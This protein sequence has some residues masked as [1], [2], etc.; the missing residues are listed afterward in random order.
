VGQNGH[1]GS[2]GY[3]HG[4]GFNSGRPTTGE[5]PH[6]TV[7]FPQQDLY[8]NAVTTAYRYKAPWFGVQA[9]GTRLKLGDYYMS[10]LALTPFGDRTNRDDWP[11]WDSPGISVLGKFGYNSYV[12]SQTDGCVVII[13]AQVELGT[14][15]N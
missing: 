5:D 2:T 8:R 6:R 9:S 15:P 10:V 4:S 12:E 13:N 1:V 7:S 3:W 11:V 14:F